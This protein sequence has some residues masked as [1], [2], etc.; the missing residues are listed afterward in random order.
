MENL[1]SFH[2][3]VRTL[4]PTSEEI[5]EV[6]YHLLHVYHVPPH[7][8]GMSH[9]SRHNLRHVGSNHPRLQKPRL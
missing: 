6:S 3:G 7:I 1:S 9:K 2:F 8:P 4:V 5:R